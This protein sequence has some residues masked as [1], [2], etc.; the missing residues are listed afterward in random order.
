MINSEYSETTA[1][2]F[3][4]TWPPPSPR[5]FLFRVAE[6]KKTDQVSWG[7][8]ESVMFQLVQNS[9]LHPNSKSPWKMMAG[10]LLS[11]WE[12]KF[13]GAMFH[14]QG[15]KVSV[16]ACSFL[17]FPQRLTWLNSFTVSDVQT[18]NHACFVV[19]PPHF[20]ETY[21]WTQMV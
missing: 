19:Y 2:Q 12:V 8:S 18:K 6:G 14:F 1:L 15:V 3:T 10:R 21:D 11:Y 17:Q 13:S 5:G 4:Q 9:K 16:V 7:H 20:I